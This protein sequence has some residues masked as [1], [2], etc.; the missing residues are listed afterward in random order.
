M[1]IL[2]KQKGEPA[3]SAFPWGRRRPRAAG[4]SPDRSLPGHTRRVAALPSGQAQHLCASKVSRLV[5][6]ESAHGKNVKR[7]RVRQ[8]KHGSLRQWRQREE[9]TVSEPRRCVLEESLANSLLPHRVQQV[10]TA[11]QGPTSSLGR[12]AKLST[13]GSVRAAGSWC[14]LGREGCLSAACS[15]GNVSTRPESAGLASRKAIVPH[16]HCLLPGGC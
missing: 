12:A 10:R 16:V 9:H 15:S 4:W 7:K 3:A 6:S 11:A 8:G 14:P 5:Q 2:W 13:S 1:H